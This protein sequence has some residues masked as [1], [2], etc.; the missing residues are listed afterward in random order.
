MGMTNSASPTIKNTP[1]RSRHPHERPAR[2][3]RLSTWLFIFAIAIYLLTPLIHLPDFPIYFFTDEAVQAQHAADLLRDGLRNPQGVFLPTYFENGG[4]YNLSLSVYVQLLPTLLFGKSVWVTRGV[5]ALLT[6]IAVVSLG[7]T[8]RNIFK[9]RLW[10]L[11]PM[12]LA[13]TPAWF[14]HSR[15]A[16]ETVLMSSLFAGF[17]YFYLR[18]RQ[19]QLKALFCAIIFGAAAFYAYSP[20]QMIMLVLAVMLLVADFRYHWIHRKTVLCG[21]ALLILLSLPYLRFRI[22]QPGS[23]SQHLIQLN[24]Y[25]VKPLP[26]NQKLLAYFT[27]YLKG[28]NPVYW[29]WPKPS[30]IERLWPDANLPAWLFSTQHDLDRHTMWGY[31][32]I[33]WV[34]FPFWVIGL[35]KSIKGFKNPA[36]RTL[37]LA[38]LAVPSGAAIV[39]W[40]IT[41]GLSFIMPTVLITALGVDDVVNQLLKHLKKWQFHHISIILFVILTLLSLGMLVDALTNG[42]TW[43]ADYG[44]SG[45]QYGGQQVFNRA[46]EIVEGDPQTTVLVSSTW[47]NASDVIMRFFTNDHPQ[48]RMGNINAFIERYQALDRSLLFVMTPEDL[49]MMAE[50]EKFTNV[51]VEEV[52][53][54][55]DGRDGFTFVRLEYIPNIE[56]I[57][58]QERAARQILQTKTLIINGQSVAVSYPTLDINE[59]GH[60]FDGD[61]TTLIRTLEANPLR[62]NL[63]FD[64]PVEIRAVTLIIGGTPT[65]VT[66]TALLDDE[67]MRTKTDQVESALVNRN[68][69]LSFE[70]PLTVDRLEIEVLSP[71]DG[72]IAH[73]HLWEVIIE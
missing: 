63:H 20:G 72:E 31:G 53:P 10:W 19:G 41:R 55:P 54:Y 64:Q 14:L 32:H 17:I 49:R 4:Q 25:W 46:V 45:M 37:L 36:Y 71:Y 5:S 26:L 15:T 6:L 35:V 42:P 43:Y 24:S 16:F 70:Q 62:L 73:V 39:D 12:L 30:I 67:E 40:G 38:T 56:E 48:V 57:F 59:I 51:T 1:S 22:T 11:G 13:V 50:S 33:L 61:P 29:F 2:D 21:F 7:L 8:L 18:Y 23:L 9:I 34:T 69:T 3:Q 28:L 27:R 47:A 44:L 60:I 68:I 58:E 52:I 65:E 66:L